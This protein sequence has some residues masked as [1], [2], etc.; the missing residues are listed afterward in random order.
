MRHLWGRRVFLHSRQA[1]AALSTP[2]LSVEPLP[3][4]WGSQVGLLLTALLEEELDCP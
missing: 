1:S 4:A 2:F 3:E